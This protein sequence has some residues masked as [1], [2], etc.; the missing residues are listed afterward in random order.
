ML[1]DLKQCVYQTFL[2][3]SEHRRWLQFPKLLCLKV[4]HVTC[5]DINWIEEM[6]PIFRSGFQR[7]STIHC[8]IS[9]THTCSSKQS[10]LRLLKL[11]V[12]GPQ[13]WAHSGKTPRGNIT[14]GL[15]LNE[16]QMHTIAQ[17][18]FVTNAWHN[19]L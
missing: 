16:L 10:S 15:W 2:F 11:V 14:T 7:S 8:F 13:I 9:H 17:L 18:G 12:E 6:E 19:L 5:F 4:I 1:Y 3:S